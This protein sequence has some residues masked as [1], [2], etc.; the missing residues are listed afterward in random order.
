[1]N[2]LINRQQESDEGL[3]PYFSFWSKPRMKILILTPVFPYRGSPAEGLF[4]EQ[5]ARAIARTGN[6][7]VVVVVKPWLPGPA[8]RRLERYRCL[9]DLPRQQNVKGL[10]VFYARYLHVP[11]YR[12]IELTVASCLH[13]LRRTVR[14]RL[15]QQR[16]DLIQVH[17]PWPA[18]LAAASLAADLGCPYVITLHIEDNP[19]LF[20]SKE[21]SA[22][23]RLMLER[24][25]AVVGVGRPLERSLKSRLPKNLPASFSIIPNG[26][27]L[28]EIQMVT[29]SH[30]SVRNGWGSL[31][32]V[33]NLWPF[34]GIDVSLRALA[35]LRDQGVPWREYVVV[36]E[37]PE[38]PRL[39]KLAEELGI[40]PKIVFK[41]G[42]KH[43]E[44]LEEI[45]RA[46]IFVLPS[47]REAFG[48]VY[49]EAMACGKPVIGCLGQGAEDIIRH[50]QDGLLV[51]PLEVEHL[52]AALR[53]LLDNPGFAMHL[54]A[55]AIRRARDFTWDQNAA[56]YTKLYR[57]IVGES[58]K[59]LSF[60][61]EIQLHPALN[62]QG[63]N[64]E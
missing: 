19:R 2:Q 59:V 58:L 15:G 10:R 31:V 23:Y 24:A 40:A 51:R 35:V 25:S 46:D 43:R 53:R 44:T 13:S 21:G 6:Q 54:G 62:S 50:E 7:V 45:A 61:R 9:A 52:A 16:F 33:G 36:G 28:A 60:P 14:R 8:A 1:M 48:I 4:N 12:F 17:T 29:G 27:D 3:W 38:L 32:S 11:R 26:V 56:R 22:L 42:L 63:M 47:W 64:K 41:G 39:R 20:S 55:Q 34:K 18:G 30:P 57:S 49:L 37:G 5:H